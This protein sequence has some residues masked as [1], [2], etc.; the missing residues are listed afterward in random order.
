MLF[1]DAIDV[2]GAMGTLQWNHVHSP[3]VGRHTGTQP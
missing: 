2:E 3:K 1:L